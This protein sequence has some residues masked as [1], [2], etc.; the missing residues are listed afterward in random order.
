MGCGKQLLNL[1]WTHHE[2]VR[3]VTHEQIREEAETDMWG[4]RFFTGHVE[5]HTH[6]VCKECGKVVGE[7]ECTCEP[8]HGQH[9]AIRLKYLA[10]TP[11]SS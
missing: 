8:E 3:Q 7:R 10:A 6:K 5:C 1:T 11:R 4:R 2:W 9:C